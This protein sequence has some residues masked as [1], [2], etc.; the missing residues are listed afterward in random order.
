ML[1]QTHLVDT[2]G[3]S[4]RYSLGSPSLM[5]ESGQNTDGHKVANLQIPNSDESM[6]CL[7]S[8]REPLSA[9]GLAGCVK[10]MTAL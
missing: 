7:E 9:T 5:T 3:T 2:F 8:P 10:Q 4:Q 6:K 1:L